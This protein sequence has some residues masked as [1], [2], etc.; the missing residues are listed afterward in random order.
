M[1]RPQAKQRRLNRDLRAT[2]PIN[3]LHLLRV[4]HFLQLHYSFPPLRL[5]ILVQL[6]NLVWFPLFRNIT[7]I[8]ILKEGVIGGNLGSP[9]FVI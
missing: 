6:M 5:L 1:G 3:D 4:L 7:I 9:Y 8:I 2:L